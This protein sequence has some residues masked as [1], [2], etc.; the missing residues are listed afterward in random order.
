MF[1]ISP[2]GPLRGVGGHRELGEGVKGLGR[3]VW[4][5]FLQLGALGRDGDHIRIDGGGVSLFGILTILR[6]PKQQAF[7]ELLG[8]AAAAPWT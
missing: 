8:L 4:S 3:P 7:G 2:Q 6:R 1:L 5:P